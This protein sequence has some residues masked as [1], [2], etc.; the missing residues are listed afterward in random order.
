MAETMLIRM[1]FQMSGGRHDNRP[2]PPAGTDFE[3]PAWEGRDL[4]RGEMA[5]PADE[6]ARKDW[7]AEQERRA[8]P[9]PGHPSKLDPR[10]AADPGASVPAVLSEPAETAAGPVA[11]P[12]RAGDPE[13][14]PE[15]SAAGSVAGNRAGEAGSTAEEAGAAE[16]VTEP[17]APGPDVPGPSSPKQAW[18]SYAV[19]QGAEPDTAS[20]MTKADLMSRYGG[21]L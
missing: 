13:P 5:D 15:P 10:P 21:R 6:Q 11:K 2:W 18:I 17:P 3:V 12:G 7:Q 8:G 16:P 20:A 4:I 1:R 19:T 14:E 9:S